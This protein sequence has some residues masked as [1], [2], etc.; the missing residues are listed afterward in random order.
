MS[1]F[2][3]PPK[4]GGL[5][6][7]MEHYRRQLGR[8][9]SHKSK[10]ADDPFAPAA[11]APAAKQETPARAKPAQAKPAAPAGIPDAHLSDLDPK[12]PLIEQA[13]ERAGGAEAGGDKAGGVQLASATIAGGSGSGAK[14]AGTAGKGSWL[15]PD[16][17]LAAA[18][19]DAIDA[20][21][22]AVAAGT[23]APMAGQQD[24]GALLREHGP[25]PRLR[26]LGALLSGTP[27]IAR[28]ALSEEERGAIETKPDPDAPDIPAGEGR[29]DQSEE[30]A[31]GDTLITPQPP[32][33]AAG[34]GIEGRP[35]QSGDDVLP[36]I[37]EAREPEVGDFFSANG[38][39]RRKAE[40]ARA[41]YEA[42][43]EEHG[44][45]HAKKYPN[46]DNS[47]AI[48]PSESPIWTELEAFKEGAK[49][50]HDG[51]YGFK[52]DRGTQSHGAEIEVYNRRTNEHLGAIDPRSG[53]WLGKR[54]KTRHWD[55][56]ELYS[57]APSYG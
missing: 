28:G 36:H 15:D 51:R 44:E 38:S 14:A 6:E 26:M 42:W 31:Q 54:D 33:T 17:K 53:K 21:T 25:D 30:A 40:A 5:A 9:G 35:D 57:P 41:R 4:R 16:G 20:G 3:Q 34:D 50:S 2:P 29:P 47:T 8:T 45:E 12:R 46:T 22:D 7:G 10:Q 39:R 18:L 27:D 49:T 52:Y 48:P 32:P 11:S 1:F 56:G 37:L 43:M 23:D 55:L 24:L 13:A 19:D